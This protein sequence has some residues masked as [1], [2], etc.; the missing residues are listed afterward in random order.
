[1][2]HAVDVVAL[3]V[4]AAWL[5]AC[6]ALLSQLRAVRPLVPALWLLSFAALTVRLA[7]PDTGPWQY[8]VCELPQLWACADVLHGVG[9]WHFWSMNAQQFHPRMSCL[10][11]SPGLWVWGD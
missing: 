2:M 4:F 1:M 11:L 6:L 5:V 10:M 3:V 7:A 8:T 9:N